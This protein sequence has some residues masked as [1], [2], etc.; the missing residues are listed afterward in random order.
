MHDKNPATSDPFHNES[1]LLRQIALFQRKA[2]ALS[3]PRNRHQLAMR[4]LY[5]GIIAHCRGELEELGELAESTGSPRRAER[6]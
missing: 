3:A 1:D 5:L 2:A 4:E 6:G